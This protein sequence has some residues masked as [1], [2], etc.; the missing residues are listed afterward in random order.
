MESPKTNAT[1]PVETFQPEC[2][3]EDVKRLEYPSDDYLGA[4]V[5]GGTIK[6]DRFL[7]AGSN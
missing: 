5:V 6:A 4:V 1:F 2:S 3:C 7:N